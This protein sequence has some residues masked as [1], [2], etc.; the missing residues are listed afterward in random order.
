MD[1]EAPSAAATAPPYAPAQ[2]PAQTP[3]QAPPD[4]GG[5]EPKA[6]PSREMTNDPVFV[7]GV[8]SYGFDDK[9]VSKLK[10][11]TVSIFCA[12]HSYIDVRC[13]SFRLVFWY[14]VL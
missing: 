8:G 4:P 2:M 14:F 5:P 1:P 10:L 11:A 6:E 13:K 12:K 9:S 3:A 7:S